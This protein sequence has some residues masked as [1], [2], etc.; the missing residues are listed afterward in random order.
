MSQVPENEIVSLTLNNGILVA[1]YLTESIDLKT[2]K[3]AVLKRMN[4]YGEKDYPVL[5]HINNV[6]HVTKEARD[7]FGSKE[8][9][10]KIKCCAIITNSPITRVL[11]NFFL[12]L[13]K[14]LVPTKMFTNEERAKEWLSE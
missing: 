4:I 6:K 1:K 13:N 12:S 2:A 14:P 11:G 3:S 10:Q 9:C 7:Y 5:V 8:S